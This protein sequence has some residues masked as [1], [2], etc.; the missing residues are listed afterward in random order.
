MNVAINYLD[1]LLIFNFLGAA[2]L[3]VYSVAYA[4]ISKIQQLFSIIPKLA[5][6]KFAERSEEEIEKT[7]TKKILKIAGIIVLGAILYVVAA[8]FIFSIFFPKYG[9][10]VFYTQL[11]AVVLLASPFGLLYTFFQS[12]ALKAKITK[13]NVAIRI[14]Q[15]VSTLTLIPLLGILGAVIARII[16]Q[17]FSTIILIFLY[18]RI[19]KK[20]TS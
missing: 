14:I 15:L 7:L 5:L 12:H 18:R 11:L 2:P 4:P 3:A 10:S 6:P 8:P 16:F 1:N 19:V 9:E 17:F 13:Y 20:P